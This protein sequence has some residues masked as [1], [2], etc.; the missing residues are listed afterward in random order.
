MSWVVVVPV[1]EHDHVAS[2]IELVVRRPICPIPNL[3][4]PGACSDCVSWKWIAVVGNL[5][6]GHL[7]GLALKALS[8]NAPRA[9]HVVVLPSLHLRFSD[10]PRGLN[11]PTMTVTH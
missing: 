6:V 10:A 3:V 9:D 5:E 2:R 11:A 1:N 8:S 7:P 4:E